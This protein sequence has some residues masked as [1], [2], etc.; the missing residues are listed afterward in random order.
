MIVRAD[1][2]DAGE[3]LT[4]QRAAYLVEAQLYGDPFLP[5]L[6]E[7][8]DQ[9]RGVIES[10]AIVLKAMDGGRVVGAVRAQFSEQTCLVG[11]LIVAP[12]RQ[13]KGVGTALLKAIEEEA[14]ELATALVL[15]TGHLSSGNLRLYKRS[16]Y[17]EFRRERVSDHLV[18]VHLRKD[19]G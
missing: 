16:G 5:P 9:M 13:G 19:L 11:R 1:A 7:T 14:A 10:D 6:V 17:Q 18:L 8:L 15:F 3:I 12:D 4:L 2:G